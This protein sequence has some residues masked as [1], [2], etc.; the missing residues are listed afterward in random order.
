MCDGGENLNNSYVDC[1]AGDFC[2][3]TTDCWPGDYC[4]NNRCYWGGGGDY[5]EGWWNCGPNQRC[6]DYWCRNAWPWP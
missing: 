4:A 1:Q 3:H 5:C 2:W 6:I